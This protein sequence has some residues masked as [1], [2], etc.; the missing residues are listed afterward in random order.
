[1]N[2]YDDNMALWLALVN[3]YEDWYADLSKLN[4]VFPNL[5]FD[6]FVNQKKELGLR[7]VGFKIYKIIDEKKW[8]LSRIKYGI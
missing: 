1:M 8:T 3:E 2:Y 6:D 4:L 7:T 5:T